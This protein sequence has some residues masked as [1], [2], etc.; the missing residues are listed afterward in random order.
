MLL[1]LSVS[2]SYSVKSVSSYLEDVSLL[3]S[4]SLAVAPLSLIVSCSPSP[5]P[6]PSFLTFSLSPCLIGTG[7][8]SQ[9][10][11]VQIQLVCVMLCCLV[12]LSNGRSGQESSW[13]RTHAQTH[14]HT[15]ARGKSSQRLTIHS[16]HYHIACLLE[17]TGPGEGEICAVVSPWSA[18]QAP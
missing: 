13:T 1:T 11:C 4:V 6:S 12:L 18:I 16:P 2:F 7:L 8:V 3:S 15:Q 10:R 9:R 5:V 17:R 14:T